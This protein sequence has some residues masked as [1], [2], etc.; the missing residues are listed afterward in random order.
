MSKK[1]DTK[2]E[3]SLKGLSLGRVGTNLK[4]GL[5]GLPN[6]GKSTFFNVLC[7]QNVPAENY[8]F[9]TID[10]TT[11]VVAVPDKRFDWLVDH[12][13]PARAVPAVLYVTDI[14]GLVRGAHQGQG[15]GN[16]FLSHIKAVDAIFH[17]VRIF[18]DAEVSHVDETIDPIRD[19]QTICD[20][21][22]YKD[23]EFLKNMRAPLEKK[24]KSGDKPSQMEMA[25][26]DKCLEMLNAGKEIRF[27][28]WKAKEIEIL[29]TYQLLTAKPMIF[30]INMSPAD[31]IKQKNKWLGKI[32]QWID[33]KGKHSIIPFSAKL[34]TELA[35]MDEESRKKF[36]EENKVQSALPRI[37]RTGY[38]ALD[39]IYFFTTGK[40]EVK[41]WTIKRGTKAPQAG[42]KIH[43]DFEKGFICAEVTSF[44]D[45]KALGSES[46][47]RAKGKVRTE[48]K[49]YEVQDGDIIFFKTSLRGGSGKK[50]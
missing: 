26:I 37:I 45:F 5:V 46:E 10:P 34:E 20:E 35:A 15:L 32:K 19:M 13:K 21:L 23:I 41:A 4:V 18:D 1:K 2:E 48:G 17:I 12:W 29:N 49:T 38:H 6:V 7:K 42:G 31:Y 44:E 24:A 25:V 39:L 30:L 40:D 16:A 8:P 47:C 11:S 50:K 28:D 33:A 9:C 27:G 22:I 36:M 14:A 43:S 3:V